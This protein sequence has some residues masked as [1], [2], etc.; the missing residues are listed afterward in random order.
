MIKL[1]SNFVNETVVFQHILPDKE[2]I[3]HLM[4]TVVKKFYVFGR[5]WI[6][7]QVRRIY[8]EKYVV[9]FNDRLQKFNHLVLNRNVVF[10]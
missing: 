6:T 4:D 10:H 8:R 9:F 7:T 2:H 3:S 1:T 5:S